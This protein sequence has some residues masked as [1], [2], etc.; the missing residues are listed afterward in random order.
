MA[1]A[2]FNP[3]AQEI[4][5]VSRTIEKLDSIKDKKQIDKLDQKLQELNQKNKEQI[6]KKLE[7]H[8]NNVDEISEKHEEVKET[9]LKII[10]QYKQACDVYKEAGQSPHPKS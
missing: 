8:N 4:G 1:V 5:E 6:Q 2:W 3:I 7:K 10:V 9:K